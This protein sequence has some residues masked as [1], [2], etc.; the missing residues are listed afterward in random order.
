[1]RELKVVESISS[2]HFLMEFRGPVFVASPPVRC[3]GWC[4]EQSDM[5]GVVEGPGYAS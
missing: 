1:M 3:S 5:M 4:G 2:S